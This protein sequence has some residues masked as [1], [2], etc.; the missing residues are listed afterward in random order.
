MGQTTIQQEPRLDDHPAA[1][2]PSIMRRSLG[3]CY[4]GFSLL[5]LMIVISAISLMAAFALPTYNGYVDSARVS[6]A[7]ADIGRISIEVERFVTNNDGAYPATLAE[8]GLA[9]MRDPWDNPYQ[10]LRIAGAVGKDGKVGDAQVRK[11]KNLKPL[12]TDFDLYSLGADGDS[13]IPLTAKASR[14]DIL[15]ANNGN[16]LGLAEDY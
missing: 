12:N 1:P 4:R 10:Y 7:V 13:K 3:F 8:I 2:T 5:E 14:D 11:D 15:R 6:T 9:D 16:F